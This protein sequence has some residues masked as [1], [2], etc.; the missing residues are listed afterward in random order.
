MTRT[1]T[2]SILCSLGLTLGCGP[3]HSAD[4]AA[5]AAATPAVA[6]APA[7]GAVAIPPT[8]LE[9]ALGPELVLADGTK[10]A[11]STLAGK[12]IALY[13]SAHWCPPCRQ[14][15]PV[16]VKTAN[17]WAAA[18]KAIAVVLVSGDRDAA[19]MSAYMQELKMPWAAVPFDSAARTQLSQQHGV[20]GIPA[21]IV[22]DATGKVLTREGRASVTGKGAAAVDG[23]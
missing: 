12:Q 5:P 19:A 4:Q 6:A 15:S 23:W 8:W 14:F 3:S 1:T 13:F 18:N 20:Q 16:L 2:V 21:L 9:T 7:A 10:V 22:L 11:T 17:E